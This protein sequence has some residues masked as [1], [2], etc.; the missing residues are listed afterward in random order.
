MST[1]D[2]GTDGNERLKFIK[3]Y[4][5]FQRTTEM[6]EYTVITVCHITKAGIAK[7]KG[8]IFDAAETGKILY[9]SK[10][11]G[12]V[13]SELDYFSQGGR[14]NQ[15]PRFWTDKTVIVDPNG[16]IKDNKQP[17]VELAIQKSKESSFKGS[18][19]F[20]HKAEACWMEEI[21][22]VELDNLLAYND[23]E[24]K[25]NVVN[26]INLANETPEFN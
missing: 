16:P 24:I 18:I 3:C 17:I 1:G 25:N 26:A 21:R 11:I 13:Y 10:V 8:E 4:D 9:S 22:G 12:M 2:A 20:R 6:L 5:W 15:T 14:R 7:G 19:F 23:R